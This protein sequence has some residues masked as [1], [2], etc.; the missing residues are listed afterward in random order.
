MS[1]FFKMEKDRCQQLSGIP[2]LLGILQGSLVC[3][4]YWF[5]DTAV[6]SYHRYV[7]NVFP[8]SSRGHKSRTSSSG[9]DQGVGKSCCLCGSPWR[10]HPLPL[11][12]SVAIILVSASLPLETQDLLPISTFLCLSAGLQNSTSDPP[13]LLRAAARLDILTSIGSEDEDLAW[14]VVCWWTKPF[15]FHLRNLS[16]WILILGSSSGWEHSTVIWLPFS[17]PCL[18]QH[19]PWGHP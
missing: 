5:P 11:A 4:W 12:A 17:I 1:V 16:L 15:F 7:G 2:N 9:W 3:Y 18:S 19:V 8:R 6:E 14:L 10:I 13:G